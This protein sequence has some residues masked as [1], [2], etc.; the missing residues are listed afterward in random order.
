MLRARV[1]ADWTITVP[2]VGSSRAEDWTTRVGVADGN[3]WAAVAAQA[4]VAQAA[5]DP[6]SG[7]MIRAVWLDAGPSA[8]GRLVLLV[9]HLAV[10]GVSWRVLLPEIGAFWRDAVA[11]RPIDTSPTATSFRRWAT[12]LA[13]E[14]QNRAAELPMWTEIVGKGTP[15]PVR[16]PLDP[17]VDVAATLL[18]V[19]LALPVDTTE[20][21]LT[22]V[23][24][25]LG[26]TIND[27]LLG[28]LGVA[29]TRWSSAEAV[30]VALEGHGREEHLVAGAD[31]SGTVGWFTTIFPICLDTT[32]IDVGAGGSAVAAAVA[33]VREHLASLPDNG[34]GYGLLRYLNPATGPVLAA[35]PHPP[36]QFNYM[37]RF[38]FPEA[39]DWEYAPEAEAAENGADDAMPETYELVVN[40]QTEDRPGGPQLTATWA[41]PAALLTEESVGG[42][43]RAWFDALQDLVT[44]VRDKQEEIR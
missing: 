13:A 16:R 10:D 40:A 19:T 32:G 27:V 6:A 12:G 22:R 8:P 31:L 41:W 25:A 20:A 15:L 39:A 24:A 1:D 18:D 43:A 9:H 2:P 17:A 4:E 36:I 30:V 7:S 5:L 35:L 21:L 14:A 33:R 34:V 11:G 29:V 26:A 42:L 44:H 28:A 3:L 37:G 38:D 23:P